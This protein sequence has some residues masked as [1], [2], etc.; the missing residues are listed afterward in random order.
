VLRDPAPAIIPKSATVPVVANVGVA[1]EPIDAVWRHAVWPGVTP[2]TA[3]SLDSRDVRQVMVVA[4]SPVELGAVVGSCGTA[5][6]V[7]PAKAP[8]VADA[9]TVVA[10]RSPVTVVASV[11]R[12]AGAPAAQVKGPVSG[13]GY[14]VQ[15]AALDS[16]QAASTAWDKMRAR[17]PALFGDRTPTV[18]QAAVHD[19]TFWRLRTGLFASLSGA[20]DFCARL[21]ASGSSC[22]TAAA[23]HE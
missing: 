22:W 10:D 13:A 17:W 6:P 4:G 19:R 16:P 12:D 1:A 15:I 9:A 2:L 18:Q 23:G 11:E 14:Y 5:S 8:V 21:R 3:G 7:A 20:N